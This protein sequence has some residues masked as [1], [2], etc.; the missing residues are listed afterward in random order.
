M[1]AERARLGLLTFD[2]HALRYRGVIELAWAGCTDDEISAYSGHASVAMIR[3]YA[4]E[5]RQIVRARQARETPM[6][7]T[8]PEQEPDNRTDN[9]LT[10]QSHISKENNGEAGWRRG[11]AAD[12]KSVK[13]GSIPVPASR[14]LHTMYL[15]PWQPGQNAL[16]VRVVNERSTPSMSSR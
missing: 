1:R 16:N 12:C 10:I 3:R 7:R 9:P 4:G 14:P 2:F 8:S 11:Y 6:N 5:A 15:R 13:T